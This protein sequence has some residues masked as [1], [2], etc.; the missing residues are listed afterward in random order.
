MKK[1]ISI[2]VA[3]VLIFVFASCKKVAD[4][5][6]SSTASPA[7]TSSPAPTGSPEASAQIPNPIV[8]VNGSADFASLGFIITPYQTADSVSYSIIG[9]TVAQIIF[10]L[11]GETYTYRAAKTT[12]DISGVY[13]TFD[14]SQPFDLEGPDFTLNV[15]VKTINGG[16]DGALA[17][18]SYDGI[19]YSFYTPDPTD[20]E[21]MTDVLLPILYVDF[22]FVNCCG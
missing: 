18:W 7:V 12:E 2:V 15:S 3:L 19:N 20:Y 8:E 5:S 4:V 13:E 14:E 10:T 11:T 16:A 6:A 22:P 17:T 1:V 21:E 9:G